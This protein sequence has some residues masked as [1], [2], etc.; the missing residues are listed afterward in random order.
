MRKERG[1]HYEL[2]GI[3]WDFLSIVGQVVLFIAEL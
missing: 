1:F 3:H 2:S